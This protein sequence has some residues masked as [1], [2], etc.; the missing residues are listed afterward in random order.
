MEAVLNFKF[1]EDR[2]KFEIIIR[3]VEFYC[4]LLGIQRICRDHTK[5]DRAAEEC[6]EDI[7]DEI[8]DLNLDNLG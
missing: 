7:L 2:N 4:S 5:Y 3:A 6:I 1:P 8:K